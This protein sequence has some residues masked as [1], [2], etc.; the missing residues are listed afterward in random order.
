MEAAPAA[1]KSLSYTILHKSKSFQHPPTDGLVR[2]A[3]SFPKSF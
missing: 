3:T 1:M 2:P